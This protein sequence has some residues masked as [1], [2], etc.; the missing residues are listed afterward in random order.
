MILS[1][2]RQKSN[3]GFRESASDVGIVFDTITWYGYALRSHLITPARKPVF[4]LL[5]V[6]WAFCAKKPAYGEGKCLLEGDKWFRMNDS[7][8]LSE[9]TEGEDKQGF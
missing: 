8:G 1:D 4:F 9:L 6:T 2:R 7:K 3:G 5:E